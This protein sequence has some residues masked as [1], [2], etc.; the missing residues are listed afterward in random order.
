MKK[1]GIGLLFA[2]FVVTWKSYEA[3]R[4]EEKYFIVGETPSGY[5]C[6]L[7]EEEK[8]QEFST[9]SEAKRFAEDKGKDRRNS[10]VKIWKMEKIS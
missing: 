2:V 5:G 10:D 3:K 1:L 6:E 7:V 8:R 4:Y 9:E